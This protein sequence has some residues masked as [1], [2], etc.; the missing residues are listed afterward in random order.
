MIPD[1][2]EEIK[3]IRHRLGAEFDYDLDRIFAD[4]QRRQAESG[5]TYVTRPSRR[6][7]NNKAMQLSGGGDASDN[8]ESTPAAR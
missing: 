3:A 1:P 2:T 6:I 8:A 5:R 4:I 7:A